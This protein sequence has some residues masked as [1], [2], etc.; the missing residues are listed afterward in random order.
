MGIIK[1]ISI[2]NKGLIMKTCSKCREIK[3]STE[4]YKNKK[5]KDGHDNYCKICSKDYKSKSL[6]SANYHKNYR[7]NNKQKNIEYARNYYKENKQ[8]IITKNCEY[9][10]NKRSNDMNFKI[11][12]NLRRRLSSAIKGNNK[13]CRTIEL[14]GCEIPVLIEYLESQFKDGMNW[15][16]YGK[17][18]IDHIRP[19]ASFDLTDIEQQ[20]ICFNYKNLQPLWAE[21]NFKKSDKWIN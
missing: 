10:K 7:D 5:Q 12:T 6:K 13:S 9:Y 8:M 15:D 17:W 3:D 1:T 4:F 19:C 21:D 2:N 20:K 11:L 18:H 16:N 14:I